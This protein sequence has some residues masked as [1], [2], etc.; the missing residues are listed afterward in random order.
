MFLCLIPLS[1][2]NMEFFPHFSSDLFTAPAIFGQMRF[3]SVSLF[4]SIF[5]ITQGIAKVELNND[6]VIKDVIKEVVIKQEDVKENV[7]IVKDIRKQDEVS[8][9]SE[10][11]FV[12]T[13]INKV[14]AVQLSGPNFQN[15]DDILVII[16]EKGFNP[17]E[18]SVKVNQRISWQNNR[19]RLSAMILGVRDILS[20]RSEMLTPQGTF[21]WSFSE[22]F[23]WISFVWINFNS[24]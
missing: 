24:Y 10:N 15:D 8:D 18:I 17:K 5:G 14:R 16:S 6:V 13:P 21:S 9:S 2:A 3:D 4:P 19:K 22:R 20:M 12:D 1:F 11:N 7:Q 23:Y